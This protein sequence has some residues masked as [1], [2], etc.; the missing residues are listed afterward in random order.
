M[1]IIEY[2][3][4]GA[5]NINDFAQRGQLELKDISTYTLLAEGHLSFIRRTSLHTLKNLK[6]YLRSDKVIL[7]VV[8]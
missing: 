7:N 4:G 3:I 1:K 5:M 6:L 8:L 2:G